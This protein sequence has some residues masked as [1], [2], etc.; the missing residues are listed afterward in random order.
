MINIGCPCCG[1]TEAKTLELYTDNSYPRFTVPKTHPK[2]Y[3]SSI[4]LDI[5]VCL[6][7]GNVYVNRTDLKYIVN[8]HKGTFE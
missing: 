1:S 3:D 7:C 8:E 2:P 5:Y 6:N 4:P